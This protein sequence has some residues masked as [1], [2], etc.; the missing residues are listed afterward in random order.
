MRS[1]FASRAWT[2][3]SLWHVYYLPDLD[4]LA[5]LLRIYEPLLAGDPTLAPVQRSWLHATIIKILPKIVV[6][7][8][9][10]E[11]LVA[12]LRRRLATLSPVPLTVG[13]ALAG[14][15]SV[16]LDVIADDDWRLVQAAVAAVVDDVLGIG[17]AQ[18][19]PDERPHITL[20]YG[21]GDGD[22]G[23]LQTRLR[24]AT[25]QRCKLTLQGVD[26]VDVIQDR[27]EH[28]YT[29]TPIAHLDLVAVHR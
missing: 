29:W 12:A 1:F 9:Q 26:L 13:P 25:D 16:V 4:R 28:T 2:A 18:I 7:D 8:E 5:P 15:S 20:A 27:C 24:R 10:R 19:A 3:Q 6:S 21:I 22:S 23:V 17:S 14:S 11:Y